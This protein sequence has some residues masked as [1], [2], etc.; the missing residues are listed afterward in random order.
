MAFTT[1]EEQILRAIM[2]SFLA[3]GFASE[4]QATNALTGLKLQNDLASAQAMLNLAFQNWETRSAE[5]SGQRSDAQIAV[6]G[7]EIAIKQF[8]DQNSVIDAT[9]SITYQQ[10]QRDLAAAEEHMD[11]IAEL[12]E[13]E[14][15]LHQ[16]TVSNLTTAVEAAQAALDAHA[17]GE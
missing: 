8:V 9:N 5:L 17:G 7:A 2:D 4:E 3:A 13:T 1:Q 15:Q 11:S 14:R 16:E 10:L 12:L 6:H